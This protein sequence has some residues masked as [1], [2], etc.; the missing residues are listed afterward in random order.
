MGSSAT[1][2]GAFGEDSGTGLLSKERIIAAPG[3]SRWLVPP[4]ALAIHL[5]IGMAY[6]FSVFW[7]P[8]SKALGIKEAVHCGPEVGF[9]GQL[10]TTSCDWSI[11]TLGWM[12]TLFFVSWAWR[13]P[14]QGG[15]L[16]RV[17]PRKVGVLAAFCWG[18][19][20][21]SRHWASTCIS[22]G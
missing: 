3:F 12:Y 15:W 11:A 16:E 2:N 5:C 19:A 21:S 7:L 22:S 13:R 9:F 18:A 10:F 6:G 17:G 14:L 20:C 1:A 8:L 4:A